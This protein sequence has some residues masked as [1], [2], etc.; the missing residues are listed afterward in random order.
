MVCVVNL[1][2]L[3]HPHHSSLAACSNLAVTR[4]SKGM[5]RR[6]KAG[7]SECDASEVNATENLAASTVVPP[8]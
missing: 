2:A 8:S 6:A 5:K 1:G 7:G 3:A 4:H